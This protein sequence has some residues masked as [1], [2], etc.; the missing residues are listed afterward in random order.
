MSL[1]VNYGPPR[2]FLLDSGVTRVPLS[3]AML[4][5]R[6]GGADRP[7]AVYS[8]NSL[9]LALESSTPYKRILNHRGK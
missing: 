9:L 4:V 7:E 6:T 2:D 3:V 1:I 8:L 5:D